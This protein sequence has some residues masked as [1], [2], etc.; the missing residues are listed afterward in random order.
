MSHEQPKPALRI[1]RPSLN[2]DATALFYSTLLGL[3]RLGGFERHNGYDG[4]FLGVL[5]ETWHMELTFHHDHQPT[6]SVEDLLVFYMDQL[7]IDEVISSAASLGLAPV[8]HPNP[9]WEATGAIGFLDP[10]GYFLIVC[11]ED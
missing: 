8:S 5:G 4:C 1:A 11:P 9:Y 7:Q 3:E 2:L 6:P 10:D